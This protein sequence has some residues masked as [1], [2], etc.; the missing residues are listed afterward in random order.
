VVVVDGSVEAEVEVE[1]GGWEEGFGVEAK[2]DISSSCSQD[3]GGWV[4]Y[5]DDVMTV[6][7]CG[8]IAADMGIAVPY[9]EE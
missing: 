3:V 5:Y 7:R 6:L 9:F 1:V 4:C 2:G 8:Q